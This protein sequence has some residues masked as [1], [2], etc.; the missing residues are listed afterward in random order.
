MF[1]LLLV[2][3][4]WGMQRQWPVVAVAVIVGLA[5][6]CR[7]TA[8]A[9][10]P[11]LLLYNWQRCPSKPRMFLSSLIMVPVGCWGLLAYMAFQYRE[12]GDA[13]AFVRAQ[14]GWAVRHPSTASEYAWSLATLEPL[15]A[16]YCPSSSTYWARHG[17][18]I[19]PLFS[20]EFGNPIYFGGTALLIFIGIWRKWL[21][22][23]E[24][25][26]A[27]GLLAIPYLTHSYR[28]GMMGHARYSAVVFPAYLVMGQLLCRM[29]SNGA[30][31]LTGS[32]GLLLGIYSALFA[33]WYPVY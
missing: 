24:F 19:N 1:L 30:V 14:E 4:L 20:L 25:L 31:L 22:S 13:F 8:M 16:K 32:F 2:I 29:P 23:R 5:T 15:W 9:L 11:T 12:F 26:L 7:A 18:D 28:S 17:K 21:N 10:L 3:S 27:V 33:S 6:A